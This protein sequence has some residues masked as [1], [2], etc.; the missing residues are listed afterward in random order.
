MSSIENP[1]ASEEVVPPYNQQWVIRRRLNEKI[2]QLA[3]QM[4]TKDSSLEGLQVLE[5]KLDAAV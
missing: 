1:F 2:K 4:V 3:L 5:Q